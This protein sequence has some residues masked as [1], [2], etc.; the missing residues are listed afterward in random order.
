MRQFAGEAGWHGRNGR[1]ELVREVL[2]FLDVHCVELRL[3][4]WQQFSCLLSFCLP[5][6]MV[7]L[8]SRLE[9]MFVL[10][11]VGIVGLVAGGRRWCAWWAVSGRIVYSPWRRL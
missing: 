11:V 5:C 1:R 4:F 3:L 8:A 7:S 6:G 9:L 2:L 10:F